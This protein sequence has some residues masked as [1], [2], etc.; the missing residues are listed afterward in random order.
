MT[1]I[2]GHI[3]G[4]SLWKSAAPLGVVG[5]SKTPAE[6]DRSRWSL[7]VAFPARIMRANTHKANKDSFK[8]RTSVGRQ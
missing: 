5:W 2:N 1:F 3:G 8:F 6:C 4:L 7:A